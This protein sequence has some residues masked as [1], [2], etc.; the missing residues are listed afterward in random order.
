MADK[1][2]ANLRAMNL[3]AIWLGLPRP[4][5]IYLTAVGGALVAGV[6][7]VTTGA[8]TGA[9]L[10]ASPSP[11]P[12]PTST[13]SAQA[14][15]NSFVGHLASDLGK[16]QEQ[17]NKAISDALG[18]TLS[19]AV[20]KGDLTQKQADAIKA[21]LGNGKVCAGILGRQIAGIGKPAPPGGGAPRAGIASLTEYAK[22]LG[23]SDQE[24]RQD[25]MNGQTVKD[26]AA[27]KG[28]DEA[29]FRAKLVSVTKA[30]LDK[31]VAAGKLTQQQEDMILQRLQNGP[32]PL[33]DRTVKR[34]S[35]KSPTATPS[36][37]ST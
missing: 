26:V 20:K 15:C 23:I 1:L 17:V 28:M 7:I 2:P 13:S 25:L 4:A 34:P 8:A 10:V 22:A 31:Q 37:T 32:L 27:S 14:Y 5:R 29:A 6:A 12:T 36:P 9:S 35:T 24:L 19:D 30:D 18:Q 33:W 3:K 11:S 21:R 16:S